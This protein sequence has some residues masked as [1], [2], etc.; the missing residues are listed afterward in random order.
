MASKKDPEADKDDNEVDNMPAGGKMKKA[1][2]GKGKEMKWKI[3]GKWMNQK[4][5]LEYVSAKDPHN[6]EEYW[7]KT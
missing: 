2:K 7:K 4:E 1:G 5:Y 6:S 3:N